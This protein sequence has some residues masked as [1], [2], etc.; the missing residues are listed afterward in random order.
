MVSLTFPLRS[1]HPV[2]LVWNSQTPHR[3]SLLCYMRHSWVPDGSGANLQLY[4]L[5]KL[6]KLL[7]SKGWHRDENEA[8][9]FHMLNGLNCPAS[10]VSIYWKRP[11]KRPSSIS[12]N[13][14]VWHIN[15]PIVILVITYYPS[16]RGLSPWIPS[17]HIYS[18]C[19][20]G[21][22]CMG[23]S[24]WMM[25]HSSCKIALPVSP[26]LHY[27][28]HR[29]LSVSILAHHQGT[30]HCTWHLSCKSTAEANAKAK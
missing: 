25:V 23:I 17:F 18:S 10:F 16:N 15:H 6:A 11:W 4:N 28:H 7:F 30:K 22:I 14:S 24:R 26:L 2:V 27:R 21:P 29:M 5:S 3:N 12:S 1:F 13:H 9:S 8:R 20:R 19:L